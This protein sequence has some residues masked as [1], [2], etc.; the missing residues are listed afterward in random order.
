MNSRAIFSTWN[1]SLL[2]S[3]FAVTK[4]VDSLVVPRCGIVKKPPQRLKSSNCLILPQ[5]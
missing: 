1:K 5:A 2:G 4:Y 3:T